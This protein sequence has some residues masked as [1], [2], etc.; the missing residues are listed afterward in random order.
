M[1]TSTD[2]T[3]GSGGAWTPLKH[4][5]N[6]WLRGLSSGSS[7]T[8]TRA[9]RVLARHVPV[10]GGAGAAAGTA[11]AGTGGIQR[12]G[13]LLAG[14]GGDGLE[15][16]LANLGLESLVGRNRFDV[17]DE[18]VTFI[19]GDGDDL[20]SEAAR[21]AACDLVDEVFGEADDWTELADTSASTITRE[22]M[23]EFMHTFLVQYVYNRV[24]VIP[25]RLS[26]ITDPHAL[27]EAD[28]DMRQLISN[29]VELRL[30]DDPFTVDWSGSEGR[31]IAQDTV[32]AAYEVLEAL[33]GDD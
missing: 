28:Q 1:G 3:S 21:D 10:L 7:N 18:L 11:V 31:Q 9:Q 27:A 24:P 14:V 4:A 5:T 23:P 8:Q 22:S 26:R 20:D 16:T 6:S 2:R 12:L 30:P 32:R 33:D 13:A 25:E 17:L 19:A 15:D 29:L